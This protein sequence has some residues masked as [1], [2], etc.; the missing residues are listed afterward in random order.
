MGD[1][2]FSFN[3][4]INTCDQTIFTWNSK[5]GSVQPKY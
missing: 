2:F 1:V 3:I 4:Y 5:A